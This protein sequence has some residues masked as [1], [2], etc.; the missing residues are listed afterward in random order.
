MEWPKPFL[1]LCHGRLSRGLPHAVRLRLGTVVVVLLRARSGGCSH[2]S[3]VRLLVHCPYFLVMEHT[4]GLPCLGGVA[5][6]VLAVVLAFHLQCRK[7]AGSGGYGSEESLALAPLAAAR[8]GRP[9]P[10]LGLHLLVPLGDLGAIGAL[11]RQGP[12]LAPA[13]MGSG[14]WALALAER[15]ALQFLAVPIWPR[16]SL[17][18]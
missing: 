12:A 14:H 11:L 13:M 18:Q 6:C 7:L 15:L 3:P 17:E 8:I 5:L 4:P 1:V 9:P 16:R 10:H 2:C